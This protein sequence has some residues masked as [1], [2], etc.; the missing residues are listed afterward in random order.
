MRPHAFCT[1][2]RVAAMRREDVRTKLLTGV[3]VIV[4]LAVSVWVLLA[5]VRFVGTTL[6]PIGVLLRDFGVQSDVTIVLLQVV[7]LAVLAVVVF[8]IGSFAQRQIGQRAVEQIDVYLG[9]IPGLGS[10]YQT[11]RQMSDLVLDPEESGSAQFREVKLVEFPGQNTY[12]L[13]FLTS[14]SPPDEVVSAAREIMD[15]PETAY[16]TLFLPLA[17][18]PVMGGHLTHVPADRVYDVD[19]EIEDAIQYILTT[20]VVDSSED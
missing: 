1:G 12:T 15:D 11:A 17:P 16:R 19:L 6:S 18:N 7:S 4:P 20:G 10:V 8:L 9:Q 2:R 3:A 14:Q 5:L 13:G